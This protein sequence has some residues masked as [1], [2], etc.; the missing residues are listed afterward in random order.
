MVYAQEQQVIHAPLLPD[1]L[2]WDIKTD[3]S[4]LYVELAIQ[5]PERAVQLFLKYQ[6][7]PLIVAIL[8]GVV[9]VA[10]VMQVEIAALTVQHMKVRLATVFH[11][12][13]DMAIIAGIDATVLDVVQV[14]QE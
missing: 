9:L 5:D 12:R 8:V 7:V 3:V 2:K 6:I 10:A 11:I 14:I 4:V 13:A 1:A